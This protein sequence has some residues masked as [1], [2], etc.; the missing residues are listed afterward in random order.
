MTKPVKHQDCHL[1]N[2]RTR[3]GQGWTG[4]E[5][6]CPS[7]SNDI[8]KGLGRPIPSSPSGS[9]CSTCIAH[10]SFH[11][12]G[13]PAQGACRGIPGQG[14]HHNRCC[15]S[16][17]CANGN[18]RGTVGSLEPWRQNGICS[19]VIPKEP[20]E[21]MSS[22]LRNVRRNRKKYDKAL[23]QDA[24][25]MALG[26][27]VGSSKTPAVSLRKVEPDLLAVM[28]N[29]Q[30]QMEVHQAIARGL[31]LALQ[32]CVVDKVEFFGLT[33]LNAC[34]KLAM[35]GAQRAQFAFNNVQYV[36]L[37]VSEGLAG[38]D[39]HSSMA[40]FEDTKQMKSLYPKVLLKIKAITV[41]DD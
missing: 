6:L 12:G 15:G 41:L 29:S 3:S 10:A 8:C 38:L 32:L 18:S 14:R 17:S 20:E 37:D 33:L 35:S 7:V 9:R 28:A 25:Y 2:A 11:K 22:N 31:C 36:A 27:A 40:M 30:E 26:A 13:P 16:G 39:R 1:E 4:I 34:L 24:G 19:T 5:S 23:V 21:S